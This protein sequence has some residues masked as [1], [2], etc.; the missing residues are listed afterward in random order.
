[1]AL[2]LEMPRALILIVLVL[3][4]SLLRGEA[5]QER[6]LKATFDLEYLKPE[7]ALPVFRQILPERQI[8]R[9]ADRRIRVTAPLRELGKMRELLE[10][11]DQPSIS[12]PTKWV[13]LHF[14]DVEEIVAIA[15]TTIELKNPSKF[16][17]IPRPRT[18][19]VF[20]MGA[21]EDMDAFAELLLS[22]DRF[23]RHCRVPFG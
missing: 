14:V 12:P 10:R 8:E 3:S 17:A 2:N 18:K 16:R 23:M 21:E 13:T 7:E 19:R 20:L 22:F 6:L 15:F 4:A 1:M 5:V 11:I 9:L